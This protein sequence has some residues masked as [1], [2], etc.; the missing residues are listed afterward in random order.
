MEAIAL[1]DKYYQE[2]KVDLPKSKETTSDDKMSEDISEDSNLDL[3]ELDNS[4]ESDSSL[5]DIDSLPAKYQAAI[6]DI[7][8]ARPDFKFNLDSLSADYL[9]AIEALLVDISP[10]KISKYIR[11]NFDLSSH[12]IH[13]YLLVLGLDLD[14][15]YSMV[16]IHNNQI[17]AKAAQAVPLQERTIYNLAQSLTGFSPAEI[18]T[19]CLAFGIDII[20]QATYDQNKQ[21][22]SDHII[23][24]AL[25]E[26]PRE[27]LNLRSL[28]IVT[29]QSRE[30][31]KEFLTRYDLS[32]IDLRRSKDSLEAI[33]LAEQQL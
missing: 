23:Y 4:L 31:L 18:E 7:L 22:E 6:L 16:R 12:Q 19:G 2:H 8:V 33:A 1:A 24:E 9:E 28:E 13:Q 26:S 25:C 27:E 30:Q 20:D 5:P 15:H 32:L 11:T 14:N 10:F 29:N 17:I 21:L 3:S